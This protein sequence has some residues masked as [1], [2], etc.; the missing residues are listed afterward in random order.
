MLRLVKSLLVTQ[1][2]GFMLLPLGGS[3]C[4]SG[5][6]GLYMQRSVSAGHAN[7]SRSSI[8]CTI[9]A[10]SSPQ[11]PFRVHLRNQRSRPIDVRIGTGS[12]SLTQRKIERGVVIISAV[13]SCSLDYVHECDHFTDIQIP[14]KGAYDLQPS[15]GLL[16]PDILMGGGRTSVPCQ[17][18]SQPVLDT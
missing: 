8:P 1:S 4:L 3:I 16:S 18:I 5:C 7:E 11:R 12:P 6:S 14:P 17:Y 9:V 2:A 15:A 13:Y 10:G